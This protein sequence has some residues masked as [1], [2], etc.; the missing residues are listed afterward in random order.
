MP[1]E[2]VSFEDKNRNQQCVWMPRLDSENFL[3]K[4]RS[5]NGEN[6]LLT[7]AARG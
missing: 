6:S 3:G 5:G 1:V 2:F 4:L 7:V